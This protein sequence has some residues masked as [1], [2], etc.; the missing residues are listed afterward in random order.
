MNKSASN[1][2]VERVKIV[3]L[4]TPTKR[5]EYKKYCTGAGKSLSIGKRL[6]AANDDEGGVFGV[7][8]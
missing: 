5:Q 3:T 1:E 6:L 2:T 4:A 8:Q 7:V